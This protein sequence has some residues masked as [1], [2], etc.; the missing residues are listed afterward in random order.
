MAVGLNAGRVVGSKKEI[1]MNVNETE[2]KNRFQED[3]EALPLGEKI[4]TLFRMEIATI[5]EA[6][7]FVV[8]DP[9]K[10]AEK[11][12]EVITEFG[13]KVEHEIRCA[14]KKSD[15]GP[16]PNRGGRDKK[17]RKARTTEDAAGA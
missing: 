9:M 3:F 16:E 6:V 12:G 4:S 7:N 1:C 8:K 15:D 5:S 10:A 2:P 17:A 14:T 13:K 11:F